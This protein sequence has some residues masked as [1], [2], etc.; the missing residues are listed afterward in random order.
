MKLLFPL[1]TWI[2]LLSASS[3]HAQVTTSAMTGYV[4]DDSHQPLPGANI[5]ATHVPSGTIYGVLS[6]EDG[7]YTIPN[8]RIGGPYL[9]EISFVGYETDSHDDIYLKLGDKLRRDI[10][11]KETSAQLGEVEV[12]GSLNSTI[13]SDRTGAASFIANDQIRYMPTISRSAADLTRLNP[14]AAEGGSFAGR[15]DQ[16][17]SYS[18][19]GSIFNN[20]FGLD[21]ATPGGQADAQPISLD[22]IDQ[23]TVNIAPYDVTQSGF[24]GASINAVTKSGTNT[25]TG[26]VFG[27][28]R[29][30]SLIGNKVGETEVTRGDL[31]Q[32]QTGF[33]FGGPLV[34]NKI[35]FFAN[36]ELERRSDLGSYFLASRPGISGDNVSRVAASDLDNI[37]SLLFQN[38]GYETGD[39]ENYKHNTD[40]Q[41]GIFKLD[42][43]LSDDHKLTA[44]V[45]FLDAFQEKPAHPSAI[46]RRGPDFQTLQFANSGYRINNKIISG[47]IELK[48]LFGNNYANKLQVG[49]T[50]FRDSRDPFSSPFP[51]LNFGK[52][53]IRYIVAGH[54]PFSINNK[55]DQNVFQISDNFNIYLPGHTLTIGGSL[56]RFAFDNSFNLTGYGF[57]VFSGDIPIEEAE[58]TLTSQ[59]FRDEVDAAIAAFE[60]NN[61]SD[62]WSLAE[63]NMGQLAFY[64]QDEWS[65]SDKFTVT[66]G[67][68]ADI[69]LYFNTAEL[70][71]ENIDRNCCYDPTIEYRDEDGNI[72]TFDHTVLPESTPLFS[73]RLGFN[74]DFHGDQRAQIRGGT[75]LFTGRFPFVWIG[76]QVANPNSFFYCVTD[77]DF[78]Y[79]QVWRS[80]LGYDRK[81]GAGWTVTMDL[82]YTKDIHAAIVKNYGLFPPT[83]TLQGVGSRPIYTA[84]DR[85]QNFGGATNA[86]V[87]TNTDLGSSFNASFQV[88]RDYNNDAGWSLAYNYLDSKDAASIDAEISSDA[89]DR[90]PAN[91]AHSNTPLLAPSLYGN[92]HRVVGSMYKRFNYGGNWATHIGLFVEYAQ[93]GRY[94]YTYSGDINNDGSGLNDLIY[95]PTEGEIASMNFGGDAAAQRAAL[96]AYI[97]QDEYLSDNRGTIAEKYGAI[98]P[99]Y[100]R[101]DLKLM[102]EYGLGNGDNIQFSIDVRNIG[103]LISPKWGVREIA[104][105]TG[106]AQPIGVSVADGVPTYSFDTAQTT[107]IFNDFSLNSRWQAQLGLRYNF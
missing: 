54:E 2:I 104:T 37:S 71:Q 20:P 4:W 11:L 85:V 38:F 86:Y 51:V 48:S 94:S 1:L 45:N 105:N 47:I 3:L 87:F 62:T 96:E 29:N 67:L 22:A 101:W 77:P 103:N 69:P 80:N 44:T 57:R 39:Y 55:L 84:A 95:I 31:Q 34:K 70:I 9:V 63:T 82:I 8:M 33:S 102:Q 78:K 17:N 23:I 74:Y 10:T 52:D 92:K 36:F 100:S 5:I 79:P 16:F 73:P 27:Y 50:A 72:V 98:S 53:G 66:L 32:F 13:N 14:M 60:T 40:N 91:P 106:L 58:A 81:L 46:G 21:A 99:W 12:V 97:D 24:T 64:G 107:S 7:G 43:N 68:R 28:F 49:M 83:G 15:N 89:Y 42:F 65:A 19:D 25:F 41:K 18:L 26:S 93:G 56:E 61:A 30:K 76:N 59:A 75:G 6:R 90:N 88:R 35:F